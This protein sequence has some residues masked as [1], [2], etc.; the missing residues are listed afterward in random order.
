MRIHRITLF[1]VAIFLPIA[2]SAEEH[3]RFGVFSYLGYED[4]KKQYEPLVEYLNQRLHKKVILEVLTQEELNQ[5]IKNKEIDIATTNPTH[6]LVIRQQYKLSGALATLVGSNDGMPVSQ[7][8]GVMVVRSDSPIK[9]IKDM[10]DKRVSTPSTKN[11]GGFRAQAYELYLEGLDHMKDIKISQTLISHQKSVRAVL[12]GSADVAFVRDGILEKMMKKGEIKDG[13]VRVINRQEIINHPFLIS[14]RL[15]PEWPVFALPQADENDVKRFV[16]ELFKLSPESHGA[17]GVGIYGYTLP[18]DYLQ[19]EDAARALRFPPFD[20]PYEISV[21]DIWEQHSLFIVAMALALLLVLI[22][23]IR[24]QGKK[25]LLESL[26]LSIG[27]GVYGVDRASR[28]NWINQKALD[29]L[30]FSKDEVLEKNQHTLFHHHKKNKE[31]YQEYECPIYL[32][33]RDKEARSCE[34]WFIK[35]DGSFFQ[36]NLSISH[37]GYGD[38]AIVVFRDI[39]DE[40]KAQE[41]MLNAKKEAEQANVA[42]SQFLANM[43]HEIRTPMGAIIGFSELLLD[44][45]LEKENRDYVEKIYDSSKLLLGIINDILDYSKVEAG[46]LELEER[47]FSLNEILEYLKRL[48]ENSA[49]SKGLELVFSKEK[50]LL[51][52]LVGDSLRISQIL[53]NLIGNAIK[54]THKGGVEVKIKNSNTDGDAILLHVEVADSGIGMSAKQMESLFVPFSQADSSTTRKYGGSGLGLVISKKLV[55]AMGGS[56][57]IESEEGVGSRFFFEIPLKAGE[58][59]VDTKRESGIGF[60]YDL[61]G[62]RVLLVEDNEVNQEMVMAMLKR[63]GVLVECASN[64]KEGVQKHLSQKGRFDIILMDMQMPVMG[65]YE[66]AELIRKEDKSIPIVALTA[67]AMIE[68]RQ[69]AFESGMNEH[70]S[71]PINSKEL[72]KIIAKLCGRGTREVQKVE[73]KSVE[74]SDVLDA[75]YILNMMGGSQDGVKR[76]YEMFLRQLDEKYG[77]LFELIG[78]NDS[79]LGSMLHSLKGASGNIGANSLHS[80]TKKVE[81]MVKSGGKIDSAIAG[82]LKSAMEDTKRVLQ[83]RLI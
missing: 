61:D 36:V 13:D 73:S 63:R 53:T 5:K 33:L 80:V 19:V 66:A 83:E 72:F 62:L 54:F 38:G 11:M 42:K 6:F 16:A 27:E 51:D 50:N 34:D 37:I 81:M 70:L 64:G 44:R 23:Y 25:R 59:R 14:T 10:K 31:G 46:K 2:L 77:E 21:K 17:K 30:G 75:E 45:E 48:F 35:K 8:G 57:W 12:D 28:C 9:K 40:K 60:E 67:A 24:E 20:K 58:S 43:S 1:F 76:V 56:M 29:M 26:L 55:S 3:I 74:S 47:Q 79:S 69:K 52:S 49:N 18:A 7:L 39:T 32:T 15:Y 71:K 65:G 4:T 41:Q 82:E 78:R 68:D 22:F